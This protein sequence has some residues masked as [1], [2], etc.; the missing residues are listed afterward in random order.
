[1]QSKA[2]NN[3]ANIKTKGE[4]NVKPCKGLLINTKKNKNEVSVETI[5][6]S[7]ENALS[8]LI[9]SQDI[10]SMTV[11]FDGKDYKL[12]FSPS[13]QKERS[14]LSFIH[15]EG[16]FYT[17]RVCGSI[18]VVGKDNKSLTHKDQI[19]IM[20]HLGTSQNASGTVFRRILIEIE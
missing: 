18:F 10:S 14:R 20:A 2:T 9:E 3:V 15:S 6:M 12:F 7:D 8:K 17:N 5:D 16:L 13:R 1:M 19:S 4:I 11:K